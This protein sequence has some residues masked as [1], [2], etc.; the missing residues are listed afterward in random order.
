MKI[1]RY[2]Y[3]I[4]IIF[5]LLP[6]L[7]NGQETDSVRVEVKDYP[8][9]KINELKADND[10]N[11]PTVIS[12]GAGFFTPFL[13]LLSRIWNL[14][15]SPLKELKIKSIE[16]FIYFVSAILFLFLIYKLFGSKYI[17]MFQSKSDKYNDQYDIEDENIHEID[18]DEEIGK[19]L[20][21]KEYRLAIRLL[22]L[23][24]LKFLSDQGRIQW[25]EGKTN[26]D[27]FFELKD[28]VVRQMFDLMSNHFNYVWYGHFEADLVRY[29]E[30]KEEFENI[31]KRLKD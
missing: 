3:F 18:F 28:P 15:T 4:L 5:A 24:T 13:R 14:L 23:K 1:I 17:G 31:E 30:A 7:G 16:T 2:G 11:Y 8:L 12:E 26:H 19:A 22:Y 29:E 9:E 6:H 27:Y 10:L 21:I 20:Y 25:E